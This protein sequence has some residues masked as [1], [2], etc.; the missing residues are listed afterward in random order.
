MSNGSCGSNS[1]TNRNHGSSC[2]AA[3]SIQSAAAL[4]R[5]RAGEVVL[6]AKPR[7]CVVVVAATE[8]VVLDAEPVAQ[9]PPAV[10]G[11]WDDAQP[12]LGCTDRRAV[13]KRAPRI[14]LVA[15]HEVPRAEVGVEVLSAR[16]EEVRV[17]GGEHRVHTRASQR[18]G[19]R[20]LP[21]FDRPPRLPQEVERAAQDVVPRRHARQ[22]AGHVAIEP[23][24]SRSESIEVRGVE[25][26][27]AVRAEHVPVERVEQHDDDVLRTGLLGTC[28]H[29]SSL[30][31][32]NTSAATQPRALPD[33]RMTPRCFYIRQRHRHEEDT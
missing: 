20:L 21:Q 9:E 7:A 25:L 10:G 4:H 22:R 1:S 14:A 15:A 12:R 31:D 17:I 26:V 29:T 27:A 2:C 19:D 3:W 6:L 8:P 30:A 18:G 33:Y 16:F 13:G 5:A 32:D 24:G 23:R 11:G 28:G